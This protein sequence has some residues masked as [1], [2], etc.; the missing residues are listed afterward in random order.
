M[1]TI[2]DIETGLPIEISEDQ[3]IRMQKLMD[4]VRPKLN[5]TQIRP[6][7]IGTGAYFPVTKGIWEQM[8]N[9][10]V[11][12]IPSSKSTK[13]PEMILMEALTNISRSQRDP[14]I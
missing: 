12:A 5:P 13:M 11:H 9:P 7:I 6:L 3:Y 14:E 1:P 8:N 10:N 2:F 4:L